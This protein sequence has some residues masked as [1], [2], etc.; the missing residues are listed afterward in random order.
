[1]LSNYIRFIVIITAMLAVILASYIKEC[2][3]Y[4]AIQEL[5]V[6]QTFKVNGHTAFVIMPRQTDLKKPIP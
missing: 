1:M 4:K 5:P 3:L 6:K 2:S